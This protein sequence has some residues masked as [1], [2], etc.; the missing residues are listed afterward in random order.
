MYSYRI[1]HVKSFQVD[2]P[3]SQSVTRAK[4]PQG[5]S[6]G[7]TF[8]NRSSID[9]ALGEGLSALV[10]LQETSGFRPSR[11]LVLFYDIR[12]FTLQPI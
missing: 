6:S 1:A 2:Q 9:F 11:W 4:S 7:E 3:G 8:L 10:C 12:E 5:W